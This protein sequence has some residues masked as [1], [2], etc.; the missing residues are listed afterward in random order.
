MNLRLAISPCP[1]DT[2]MFY[3]LLNE[4]HPN[5]DFEFDVQFADIKELNSKVLSRDIDI[6]KMSFNAYPSIAKDYQILS[7]G[8]A[9]GRNCGPLVIAKEQIPLD[10]LQEMS[11]AIPGIST[12]AHFLLQF[13]FP[14][15][16]KK[17]EVLFSNIEDQ[18]LNNLFDCGLIIHENRF[19]YQEKGLKKII[20][21]GEYWE[22]KTGFPIPL[23]C[24]VIRRDIKEQ[25]KVKINQLLH[26]SI[27]YAFEHPE[28]TL[29]FVAKYAQEMDLKVMQQHIDLYVNNYSLN[30]GSEGKNAINHL[31]TQKKA[32]E[33]KKFSFQNTYIDL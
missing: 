6:C 33:K 18:V 11:F 10:Q 31:F 20:D 28:E 16:N 4:H 8:S 30:L 26:N 23:G 19:T 22:E 14:N 24:I 29:E 1:N 17:S 27:K 21:L 2:F 9:L 7:S 25:T 15:I 3:K 32:M 12:T 13:A 5:E